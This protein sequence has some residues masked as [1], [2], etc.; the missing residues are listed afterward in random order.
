[1]DIAAATVTYCLN[2]KKPLRDR[3]RIRREK[4]VQESARIE[5]E[6]SDDD[7]DDNHVMVVDVQ[8]ADGAS[9]DEQPTI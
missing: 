1:M 9:F 2:A 7:V 3:V 5:A 8:D 6:P 4:A